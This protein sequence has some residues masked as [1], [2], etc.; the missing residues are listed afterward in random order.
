MIS[1]PR[2]HLSLPAKAPAH[3]NHSFDA[4]FKSD[5]PLKPTWENRIA[6][7]NAPTSF[8]PANNKTI[9]CQKI[10][11][12][13]NAVPLVSPQHKTRNMFI[14]MVRIPIYIHIDTRVCIIVLYLKGNASA[15][16]RSTH[17]CH[18]HFEGT[19]PPP[20]PPAQMGGFKASLEPLQL[21]NEAADAVQQVLSR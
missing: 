8:R 9:S 1:A 18:V 3:S 15:K 19:P 21:S 20:C 11:P 17:T 13:T 4:L 16:T 10:T 14:S 7:T 12:K 5:S 6:S 2:S